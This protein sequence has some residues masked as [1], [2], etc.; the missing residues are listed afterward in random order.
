MM[1]CMKETD[2]DEAKAEAMLKRKLDL[3]N[4]AATPAAKKAHVDADAAKET[5]RKADEARPVPV[6]HPSGEQELAYKVTGVVAA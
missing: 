1:D 2:G 6:S 4:A 3:E 5:Q